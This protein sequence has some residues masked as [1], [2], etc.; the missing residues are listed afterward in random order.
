MSRYARYHPEEFE[1]LRNMALN[2]PV[3]EPPETVQPE[4]DPLVM[5]I[6]AAQLLAYLYQLEFDQAEPT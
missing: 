4:Y 6:T 3:P 5:A 1:C 2:P